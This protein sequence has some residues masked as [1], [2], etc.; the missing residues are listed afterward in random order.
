M[1]HKGKVPTVVHNDENQ[2][3]NANGCYSNIVLLKGG[4][5]VGCF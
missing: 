2:L 4:K 1:F 5:L 3:E